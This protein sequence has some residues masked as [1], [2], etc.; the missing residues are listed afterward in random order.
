MGSTV[1]SPSVLQSGPLGTPSAASIVA[2]LKSLK[3]LI[4]E[5][6]FNVT[7]DRVAGTTVAQTV[8]VESV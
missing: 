7:S 6:R 3:P 1:L 4:F 8:N 5:Y 2:V